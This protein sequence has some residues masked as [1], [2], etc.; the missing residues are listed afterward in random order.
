MVAWNKGPQAPYGRRVLLI[1]TP[2]GIPAADPEPDIV[3]GHWH[4]RGGFVAVEPPYPRDGVRPLLKV[5]W[6]S[7]IPDLP[8]EVELRALVDGDL[9]G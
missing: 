4:D 9:K 8:N 2:L 1:A 6:W 3:I 5:H 7:E